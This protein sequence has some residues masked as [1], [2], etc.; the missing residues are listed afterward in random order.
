MVGPSTSQ[1]AAT[2]TAASVVVAVEMR[3]GRRRGLLPLQLDAPVWEGSDITL[4]QWLCANVE[5]KTMHNVTDAAFEDQLKLAQRTSPKPNSIP[6]S[7]HLVRVILGCKELWELEHHI[8]PCHKHAYP[9]LHPDKWA[10]VEQ[11]QQQQQQQGQQQQ[12]QQQQGQQQLQ[13]GQQQHQGEGGAPG[14][15]AKL[16]CPEC[17]RGRFY[18]VVSPTGARSIVPHIAAGA[19]ATGG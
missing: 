3:R 15:A 1:Y 19:R 14:A 12:Q 8:C 16:F 2:A 11:Q 17:G 9:P 18:T 13:Q 10:V 6:S 5:L 4:R 7:L